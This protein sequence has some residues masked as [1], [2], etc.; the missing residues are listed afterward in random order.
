MEDWRCPLQLPSTNGHI[1]PRIGRLA[2]A[3]SL[4]VMSSRLS[5]KSEIE[6]IGKDATGP[7][8]QNAIGL[9]T[10]AHSVFIPG[11]LCISG[12]R[13]STATAAI[14]DRKPPPRQPR[15][16]A[17]DRDC[18]APWQSH[19]VQGFA[20]CSC[21]RRAALWWERSQGSANAQRFL[22]LMT[23]ARNAWRASVPARPGRRPKASLDH[24]PCF[25][26][27]ARHL[28]VNLRCCC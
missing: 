17:D 15:L 22:Q 19:R 23:T 6:S 24:C 26:S 16:V 21:S 20:C 3:P 5:A 12:C 25:R 13:S 8:Q 18:R 1:P 14:R 27:T 7:V 9:D 28:R 4:F 2:R 10:G 11:A